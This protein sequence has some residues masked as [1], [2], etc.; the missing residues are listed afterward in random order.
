MYM[1]Q[2]SHFVTSVCL[3]ANT[4]LV[5]VLRKKSLI[6]IDTFLSFPVYNIKVLN[7]LSYDAKEDFKEEEKTRK[8][9]ILLTNKCLQ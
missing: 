3:R 1:E 9:T 4:L 8:V 6:I 5:D 2:S 7:F